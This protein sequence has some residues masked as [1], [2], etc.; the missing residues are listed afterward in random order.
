MNIPSVLGEWPTLEHCIM[1]RVSIARYGDGELRLASGFGSSKTQR[2]R[3]IKLFNELR[4]GLLKPQDAFVCIPNF[5]PM[6]P[7]AENW[8]RYYEEARYGNLYGQPCY[9]S[10]FIT[11]PDNA[12]WINVWDYWRRAVDLWRGRHVL[13]VRG[14]HPGAGLTNEQ[15]AHAKSMHIIEGPGY[16][17]YK[18]IDNLEAT[19]L[20]LWEQIKAQHGKNAGPV[21]MCLGATATC[22]A[23]RLARKGVWAVDIGNIG[24]FIPKDHTHATDDDLIVEIKTVRQVLK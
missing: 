11:R 7:K 4:D 6:C 24:K 21:L 15:M 12:P 10:S 20:I 14:D 2:E 8:K 1:R 19:I 3:P 5:T 18:A 23:L 9:G 16:E 13:L 22:L 17:A